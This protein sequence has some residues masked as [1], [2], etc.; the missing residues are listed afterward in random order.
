MPRVTIKSSAMFKV[1]KTDDKSR[2]RAGI[3]ET[4]HGEIETPAYAI[5]GSHGS[6]KAVTAEDL[7]KAGTQVLMMNTY[8]LWRDLGDDKLKNFIGLHEFSG[9]DGPIMTDSGG[10][11]VFSMGAGREKKVGKILTAKN[12]FLASEKDHSCLRITGDGVYFK[13]YGEEFFLD[14]KKSMWIQEHLGADIIFAFDE[15]TSPLHNY[16]YNKIALKR[17]H[18]WANVCLSER[19]D[20]KQLL[21]GIVQGGIFEDLR[22]ESAK[23]IGSLPFDGFAI[24]GSFGSSFN[25]TKENTYKE[26]NWTIPYLLED[27][28]R[29]LLGIGRIEDIFR[30][31]KAGIDT[32][33][34]V[35][36]TR[37]ARH[38]AVW[39]SKGRVDVKSG[40]CRGDESPIEDG[41][42]CS[43]C[44]IV[45]IKKKELHRRFR[46]KNFEA[47][48]LATIHNIYF[49]N[50]LMSKIRAAIFN[51]SF[52]VLEKH[53]LGSETSVHRYI[54]AQ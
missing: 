30:A 2:A 52:E 1:L 40:K 11:Q 39:T 22:K 19:K 9:W 42:R 45:G 24:G 32:F 47:G 13:D 28:P 21:Y 50:N 3:I 16:E 17:T 23:Y 27:K 12:N 31:V 35:I 5:V 54:H 25:D 4:S 46:E 37:E 18:D 48:K 38:G 53:I 49:F 8:H 33:D 41:C 14:P 15:P 10:F 44:S 51:G 7:K 43:S 29:H 26:L 36:P 6:V 34:C 20:N